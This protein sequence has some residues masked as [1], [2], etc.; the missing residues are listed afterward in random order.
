MGHP[1]RA[2]TLRGPHRFTELRDALPGIS[3]HTLTSRL[4]QFERYGIV[5]P[6]A[7]A[8]IPPH[9]SSTGSPLWV[10]DCEPSSTGRCSCPS[11]SPPCH[12]DRP[13]S[14]AAPARSYVTPRRARRRSAWQPAAVARPA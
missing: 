2:R 11:G 10:R 4:R 9:G 14:P 12:P 5:T 7:Y 6:T 1:H 3:P 8:E 13:Q